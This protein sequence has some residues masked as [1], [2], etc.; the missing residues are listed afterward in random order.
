MSTLS[1]QVIPEETTRT[2]TPPR[3][4]RFDSAVRRMVRVANG[5]VEIDPLE[6]FARDTKF[7]VHDDNDSTED[8]PFVLAEDSRAR[9][10]WD[11]LITFLIA[12]YIVVVPLRIA[13]EDSVPLGSPTKLFLTSGGGWHVVDV[14]SDL[15]FIFDIFLNFRTAIRTDGV[16]YDTP[17]K[18]AKHYMKTWFTLGG[19]L[20]T[21]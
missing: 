17:H 9:L 4:K 16:V 14:L 11:M 19:R 20:N 7:A 8:I 1:S 6:K 13:F 18:I 21:T 12:F 15:V 10:R 2:S 3:L 5:N